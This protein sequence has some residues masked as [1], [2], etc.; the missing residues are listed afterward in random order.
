MSLKDKLKKIIS[1]LFG[2]VSAAQKIFFVQ[3]L[4]IMTKTGISMS[5]ALS[6]LSEQTSNKRFSAVLADLNQEV[7]KGNALSAG[8]EKH[9]KIFGDLFINMIKS[10]EASGKLEEV[11][12][13]LFIQIK[14]DHA[15]VSKVRGALIYPAVVITAMIGVGSF[16]VLYVIPNLTQVFTE[17]NAPLPLPTRLL[18]GFSNV[19][20]R[21]GLYCL[22]AVIISLIIAVRFIASPRG[23]YL[24]H[25]ALLKLPI[26]GAII[27]KINL[28]RFCRTLSSLLK[29][30]IAIVKS[31]EITANVLS[32][33]LY[34]QALKQAKEKVKKGE[35][36]KASLS[37]YKKL[38]PPVVLQ[39]INVGE[40]T[41][42][43]A[44]ILEEAAQFYEDDIDRTMSN[45]P[46]I[47]EP[48]LIVILG[49]GVAAMAVAIIMPM[50][51]L[52]QQI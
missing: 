38:I 32:N 27:K 37:P 31:F 52:S 26:V 35:G 50:Y 44:N 8:M 4:G 23:K 7:E 3:Q 22:A 39:M 41:G 2:H 10:G 13:Q 36:V 43:L 29:T 16:V 17:I 40:E 33:Q 51:S 21:Y 15:L 11:L 9:Q 25:Q 6:T 48:I 30:D 46:S 42:S 14:K 1:R 5:V 47:I 34:K 49:A 20:S 18:I 24:W 45:L 12:N 28:A 19:V